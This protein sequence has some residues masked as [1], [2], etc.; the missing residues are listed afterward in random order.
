MEKTLFK[1]LIA[2]LIIAPAFCFAYVFPNDSHTSYV[3]ITSGTTGEILP[4]ADHDRTI[5]YA[6][7]RS[8]PQIEAIITI[9]GV[10]YFNNQQVQSLEVFAP[11][12]IPT[13]QSVNYTKTNN[14][15]ASFRIV[16]VDYDLLTGD[17]NSL[18]QTITDGTNT[19][20]LNK[21]VNYGELVVIF[22]LTLFLMLEIFKLVFDFFMPKVFKVFS[23]TM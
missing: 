12:K 16:Y 15:S 10:N 17:G 23:K 7:I 18:T 20:Y 6:T 8:V 19:F 11:V 1:L 5:L 2:G 14:K 3:E 13:G 22:F 9:G 21:S 4:A